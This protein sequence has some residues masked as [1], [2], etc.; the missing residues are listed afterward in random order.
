[1]LGHYSWSSKK[2]EKLKF[3]DLKQQKK[4]DYQRQ[5]NTLAAQSTR[6]Q[7]TVWQTALKKKL[8]SF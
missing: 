1:M 6:D 8:I 5:E 2:N 7:E 3:Q 4:T